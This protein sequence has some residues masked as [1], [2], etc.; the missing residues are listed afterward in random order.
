MRFW[1]RQVWRRDFE[2]DLG[3]R[4]LVGLERIAAGSGMARFA[5][6]DVGQSSVSGA[7]SRNDWAAKGCEIR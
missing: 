3:D 6:A 1:L 5:N 4:G 2:G 7:G